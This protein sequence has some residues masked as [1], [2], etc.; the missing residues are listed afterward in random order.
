MAIKF[1]R[2]I[3]A[4][5]SIR[6]FARRLRDDSRGATLVEYSILIGL[7]SAGVIGLVMQVGGKLVDPWDSL[8]NIEPGDIEPGAGGNSG[9][10]SPGG[11][12]SL[13]P[14]GGDTGPDTVIS[15]LKKTSFTGF[16]ATAK[17]IAAK[18]VLPSSETMRTI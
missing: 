4:L 6:A 3:N 16:H 18:A 1:S 12:F 7:L 5:A 9:P 2:Q 15:P 10:P 17:H 13:P 8:A 14:P 11:D